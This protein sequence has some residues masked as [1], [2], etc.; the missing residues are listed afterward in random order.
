MRDSPS[1]WLCRAT[2]QTPLLGA[3]LS[4]G[5]VLPTV[6]KQGP[7]DIHNRPS[8]HN[9]SETVT[10]ADETCRVNALANQPEII[11]YQKHDKTCRAL[12][13]RL[14][15]QKWPHF[16]PP[17]LKKENAAHFFMR[18]GILCRQVE[19]CD[20]VTIV[21][22]QAKRFEIMHQNHD[23]AHHAHCGHDKMHEKLSR[24]IWY[25]GLRRDCK[26]Y[27]DSCQRCSVAKDDRGPPSPPLVSQSAVGP[28]EVLVVD[29]VHM[30]ASR[31]SGKT[32]VLTCIDKFTGFLTH[33]PLETGTTDGIVGALSKQ[34]LTFGPPKHMETDA[35]SN[36]KSQKLLGFCQFWDVTVRH[37]VG[38]HHE[39]IGKVERRHRDI[40]R[41]LRAYPRNVTFIGL[42]YD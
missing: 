39:G 13:H 9:R 35:G 37:A 19:P 33:Y 14:K 34:F 21:W 27:V 18:G 41:R 31:I 32:L 29:V 4:Q 1:I 23:V 26:N 6:G 42:P 10:Q 11:W 12:V 36:F 15:H 7:G 40:K 20:P 38:G 5:T 22:P 25:P 2:C 30:P 28:G 8:V 17:A 3:G 24:A 16:C